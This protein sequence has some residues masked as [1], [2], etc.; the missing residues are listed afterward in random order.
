[1]VTDGHK[2]TVKGK[3]DRTDWANESVR[4]RAYAQDYW[5]GQDTDSRVTLPDGTVTTEGGGINV[6]GKGRDL[7]PHDNALRTWYMQER[8]DQGLDDEKYGTQKLQGIFD[9]VESKFLDEVYDNEG[10]VNEGV[11]AHWGLDLR[12]VGLGNT[13]EPGQGLLSLVTSLGII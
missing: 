13:F 5:T 4:S 2:P 8:T 3:H 11:E 7:S 1:M 6:A 12:R 9:N 10:N